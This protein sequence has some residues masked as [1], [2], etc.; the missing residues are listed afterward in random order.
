MTNQEILDIFKQ[1]GVLQEG[2][3]ILTSGRHSDRYMQ[4]A[5][6]FQFTKFSEPICKELASKFA[7][8]KIDA[9][10]GPALGAIQM[11]Y[12]VSRHLNVKNMFAER[13]DGKMT[14]RRGFSIS[15]G[16]RILVVEDVVTTGGSVKEVLDIVRELGGDPVGVGCIVDRSAG[17]VDFGVPLISVLSMEIKSYEAQECPLCKEGKIPAI[18]PG[19][20]GKK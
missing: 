5:K 10:I 17:N 4:C 13:V 15:P 9:V 20:S 2:H 3:F 19:S 18:K 6:L 1:A 8:E 12:E 11:S 14:L 16:D 7:G